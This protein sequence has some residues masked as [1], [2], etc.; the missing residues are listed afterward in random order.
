MSKAIVML[1]EAN[2]MIGFLM[3]ASEYSIF[4]E[5]GWEGH[6]IFTGVPKEPAVMDNPLCNY[7]QSNKNIEFNAKI[8]SSND[9]YSLTIKRLLTAKLSN[10]LK[11]SWS[12]IDNEIAGF[13]FAPNEKTS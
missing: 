2:E 8:I 6:C 5:M 7:L 11:G 4:D 1:T 13:C 3:F 9:G 10:D 12:P